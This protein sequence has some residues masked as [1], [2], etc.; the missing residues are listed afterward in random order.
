MRILA[1][2]ARC[3][4]ASAFSFRYTPGP[5]YGH[6]EKYAGVRLHKISDYFL[7]GRYRALQQLIVL[8]HGEQRAVVVFVRGKERT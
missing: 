4:F 2:F 6:D 3:E 8:D 7:S 1:P 5:G